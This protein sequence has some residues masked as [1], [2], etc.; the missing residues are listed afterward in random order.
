M[1]DKERLR[2]DPFDRNYRNRFRQQRRTSAFR[3]AAILHEIHGVICSITR[4]VG[5]R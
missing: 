4:L 2:V 5:F 1:V 3:S